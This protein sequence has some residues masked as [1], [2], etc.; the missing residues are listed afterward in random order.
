MENKLIGYCHLIVFLGVISLLCS[1]GNFSKPKKSRILTYNV[2]YCRSNGENKSFDQKN[3]DEIADVIKTLNPDLVALQELDSACKERNY[4]FLLEKINDATGA[5]YQM[6]YGSAEKYNHGTIGCGVLIHPRFNI[7]QYKKIPL[8]GN[9]GRICVSV[10]LDEFIFMSTHLD[11]NDSLREESCR[12]ILKEISKY[13]KPVFLAGDLNDSHRWNSGFAKVLNSQ[14]HLLSTEEY[15]LSD[16][17]NHSTI[18]YILGSSS[19]IEKFM[20]T[21]TK[22]LRNL[23]VGN[24]MKDLTYVSDH[25]PVYVDIEEIR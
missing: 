21:D 7:L 10:E 20:I 25:L 3:I 6:V 22:A 1:C 5:N 19:S 15:T 24:R 14:M 2:A 23:K 17:D 13:K 16:K 8:P 9:E 4:R 12:I 11:L 18:D